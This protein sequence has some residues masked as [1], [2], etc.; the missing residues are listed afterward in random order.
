MEIQECTGIS[1][2]FCAAA[3]NAIVVQEHVPWWSAWYC[4]I[5]WARTHA[6]YTAVLQT[7]PAYLQSR[8]LWVKFFQQHQQLK[9]TGFSAS[10]STLEGFQDPT[11]QS[12]EQ[13]GPNSELAL[14]WAGVW[15]R[16]LPRSLPAWTV[17]FTY[18]TI[19]KPVLL[20]LI[21][22]SGLWRRWWGS[23]VQACS[24][25]LQSHR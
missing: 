2:Y 21:L 22:P 19:P 14:L 24:S 3:H 8:R 7:C 13:L 23:Q 5:I 15:T 12:W 4:V 17:L 1:E 11:G 20:S 9:P 10:F 16:D 6:S 18:L 25:V